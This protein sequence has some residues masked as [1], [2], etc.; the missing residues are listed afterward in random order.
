M[1][2][3]IGFICYLWKIVKLYLVFYV[4]D[5]SM[6]WFVLLVMG[7]KLKCYKCSKLGYFVKECR[8]VLENRSG[9]GVSFGGEWRFFLFY[10]SV[11]ENYLDNE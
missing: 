10:D 3:L 2:Y 1:L 6:V 5:V 11:I 7:L 4:F 8:F 9:S